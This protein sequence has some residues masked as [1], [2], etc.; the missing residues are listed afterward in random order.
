[1][2]KSLVSLDLHSEGQRQRV[3]GDTAAS[4]SVFQGSGAPP[5]E[6]PAGC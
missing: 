5:G 1:M 4:W 3:L 2:M 6:Q